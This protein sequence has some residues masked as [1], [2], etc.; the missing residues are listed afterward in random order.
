MPEKKTISGKRDPIGP[1]TDLVATAIA[2]LWSGDAMRKDKIVIG[3]PVEQTS[4][5]QDLLETVMSVER[6]F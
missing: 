2:S 1:V 3:V 6:R 4:R 5:A